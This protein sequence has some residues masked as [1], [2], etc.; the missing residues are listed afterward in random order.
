MSVRPSIPWLLPA[1]LVLAAAVASAARAET[2]IHVTSNGWHTGI[3]IARADLP[4]GVIPEIA[5]FPAATHFEFG[6]GNRDYYTTPR[7]T[8]GLT[9]G[10]ALPSA[11]VVHLA[12]YGGPPRGYPGYEVVTLRVS[13][14]GMRRLAAYLHAGFA[15]GGAPRLRAI[16]P[17]LLPASA[18][19]PGSGTFHLFN[20]CNTW[21][22]AGLA[23]AGLPVRAGGVQQA[24]ELMSQLRRRARASDP[25]PS[26]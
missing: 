25:A 10:A 12:A 20:T 11:A 23:A 17:G 2:T 26:R 6:W 3:V 19:Y 22:A 21:V 1:L 4:P 18:F 7:K 16:A 15:R 8:L 24:E 5:D 14:E 13:G 9:L